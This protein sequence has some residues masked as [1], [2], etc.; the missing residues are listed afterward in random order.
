[1]SCIICLKAD[2]RWKSERALP[3]PPLATPQHWRKPWYPC[4]KSSAWRALQ[5]R[6]W[7]DLRCQPGPQALWIYVNV[8]QHMSMT[9][10]ASRHTVI[11]EIKCRITMHNEHGLVKRYPQTWA[12]TLFL[13]LKLFLSSV[14]LALKQNSSSSPDHESFQ[15]P[16]SFQLNHC[17]KR[18]HFMSRLTRLRRGLL[19]QFSHLLQCCWDIPSFL[20]SFC[21]WPMPRTQTPRTRNRL[22][23]A[24]KIWSKWVNYRN[25]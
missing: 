16:N 23:N 22:Q 12:T 9:S 5:S 8:M 7:W 4:Y 10:I 18:K 2:G 17:R 20:S 3:A 1:M 24:L 6:T 25:A 14:A 13:S 19:Q 21:D 11:L 15:M